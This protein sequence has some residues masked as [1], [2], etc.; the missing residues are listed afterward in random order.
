VRDN[1]GEVFP[2]ADRLEK[3]AIVAELRLAEAEDEHKRRGHGRESPYEWSKLEFEERRH[4]R[5]L[6]LKA[7]T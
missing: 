3:W 7:E 6:L 4:L 1:E 5:E 2:V